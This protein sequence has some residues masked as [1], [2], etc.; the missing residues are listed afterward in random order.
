MITTNLTIAGLPVQNAV[1]KIKEV[2]FNE[3]TR[4]AR[5]VCTVHASAEIA[6]QHN[7]PS[8]TE[9][10]WDIP[11]WSTTALG[12]FVLGATY[13]WMVDSGSVVPVV[14]PVPEPDGYLMN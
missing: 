9:L 1:V 4:T 3:T 8:L 10:V 6:E 13:D 11:E 2:N 14:E 12:Q 5:V 7:G